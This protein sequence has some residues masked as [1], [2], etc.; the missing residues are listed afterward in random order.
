M[1]LMR[2][3]MMF[4][5]RGVHSFL[6]GSADSSRPLAWLIGER[7][8][9]HLHRW[10]AEEYDGEYSTAEE[11]AAARKTYLVGAVSCILGALVAWDFLIA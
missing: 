3:Q 4:M 8:A 1:S 10:H 7:I 6:T 5:G 2:N 9:F 11:K